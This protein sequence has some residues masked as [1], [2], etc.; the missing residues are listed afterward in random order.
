MFEYRLELA[1][2]Y[3]NENLIISAKKNIDSIMKKKKSDLKEKMKKK[4]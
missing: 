3:K 1:I 4:D 2:K